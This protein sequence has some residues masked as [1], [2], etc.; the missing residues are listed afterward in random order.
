MRVQAKVEIAWWRNIKQETC[1]LTL[2]AAV[3]VGRGLKFE[4]FQRFRV[5]SLRSGEAITRDIERAHADFNSRKLSRCEDCRL[6]TALKLSSCCIRISIS[7]QSP[8]HADVRFWFYRSSFSNREGLHCSKCQL[9]SRN[10]G[11]KRNMFLCHLSSCK[12]LWKCSHYT[13]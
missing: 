9:L 7:W 3:A 12:I 10:W 1:K 8:A 11:F 2:R 6:L 5:I 13:F 4:S